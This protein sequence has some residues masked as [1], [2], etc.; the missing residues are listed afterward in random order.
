MS[1]AR[2][3]ELWDKIDAASRAMIDAMEEAALDPAWQDEDIEA[4]S[5][6]HATVSA[7]PRLSLTMRDQMK[8][9]T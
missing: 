5:D 4:W 7:R 2:R 3:L 8:Q 6:V 1:N 9:S